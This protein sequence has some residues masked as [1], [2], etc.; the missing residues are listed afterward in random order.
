VPRNPI[1]T[2]LGDEIPVEV[3]RHVGLL[4]LARLAANSC[5]RFAPPFLATIARGTD[6]TLQQ[7]GVAV[8]IAELAG[9]LSPLT[10]RFVDKMSRRQAMIVGLFGVAVGTGIAASSTWLVQFVIGLIVLGQSKVMFDLGLGSWVSDHVPD[11]RRGR[12]V[13]LTETSW[14]GGLLIGVSSMGLVTAAIG[15]RAGYAFG[16]IMVVLVATAVA[17]RLPTEAH[18]TEVTA[19]AVAKD[20]LAADR[21]LDARGW[22]AFAATGCLM[23]AVQSVFVTFGS[24]LEDSFD[25]TATMLS[26]VAFGLGL[27]ELFASVTSARRTDAWGKERSVALGA[28]LM[29]PAAVGLALWHE[30]LWIALPLLAVAILGFEFAIVS[31]IPIGLSLVASSPAW[32]LGMMLA[33]GTTGRALASIPATRLYDSR[34]MAWP[35]MMTAVL[36]AGCVLSIGNVARLSK[37]ATA[38]ARG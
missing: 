4:T 38:G 10:A 31:S 27:G 21:R 37:R 6:V 13:G 18:H 23:A 2:V 33:A 9:L 28:A 15:W 32:G 25:F 8:A 7:I 14:A 19:R 5:F 12:V 17:R 22:W 34:G 1:D 36:A 26:A 24:W 29:V 20:G 30:H 11:E 3:R 16:A 35:A